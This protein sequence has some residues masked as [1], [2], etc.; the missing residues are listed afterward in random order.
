LPADDAFGCI[1]LVLP[2]SGMNSAT[3]K[4][5]QYRWER[6]STSSTTDY[7]DGRAI[8]RTVAPSPRVIIFNLITTAISISAAAVAVVLIAFATAFEISAD[9]ISIECNQKNQRGCEFRE[10]LPSI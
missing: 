1:A 8:Y 2:E 5:I 6:I 7:L 3:A 10:R 4:K 9:I